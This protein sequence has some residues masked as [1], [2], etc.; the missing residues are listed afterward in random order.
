[1]F[2]EEWQKKYYRMLRLGERA[3]RVPAPRQVM[4]H[5]EVYNVWSLLEGRVRVMRVSETRRNG[6]KVSTGWMRYCAQLLW[7]GEPFVYQSCRTYLRFAPKW[8]D[9]LKN[10]LA[11]SLRRSQQN[12]T[13]SVLSWM[14]RAHED[15]P[16]QWVSELI[17][18]DG[19]CT[20]PPGALVAADFDKHFG[21]VRYRRRYFCH[22]FGVPSLVAFFTPYNSFS[23]SDILKEVP[24]DPGLSSLHFHGQLTCENV[25]LHTSGWDVYTPCAN[26]TW[27]TAHDSQEANGRLFGTTAEPHCR[28]RGLNPQH[29]SEQ[30]VRADALLDPW[31]N[32]L[33]PMDE[34]IMEMPL[35]TAC[36]WTTL[37]PKDASP[38]DTGRRVGHR[39]KKGSRRMMNSFE[40]ETG[41]DMTR[42]EVDEKGQNAGFNGDRDF[43]DSKAAM[44]AKSMQYSKQLEPE[45]RQAWRKGGGYI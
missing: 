45:A 38:W 18:S 29:F 17:D 21:W 26:F 13:K 33:T 37:R 25:R 42:Q 4:V 30:K 23:T 16:W 3:T 1:M 35:P 7:H 10:D 39:F 31:E 40:R 34:E 20:I 28:D 8:D 5:G 9:L 11:V 24:A 22:S 44:L 12:G 32:K 14:S 43:E 36:F 15:E 2:T 6:E 27:E 19:N 41:V